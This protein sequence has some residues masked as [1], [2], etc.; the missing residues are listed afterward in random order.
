MSAHNRSVVANDFH[1]QFRDKKV[2]SLFYN[3]LRREKPDKIILAG[4]VTDFYSISRFDKNPARKES[5]Q[6]ELDDSHKMLATIRRAAPNAKIIFL[7]GN[8]EA[9]LTK[10]LWSTAKALATLRSLEIESLLQ[11]K[12]LN[13]QYETDGIWLGDL[14]VYHGTIVRAKAAYTAHA[15]LLKNGCSGMS[16]HTHRDGKAAVRHRGGQLCWWENFCMCQLDAEYIKGIA[17]W[18]QGWSLVTVTG[19]RPDVEQ[20]AVMGGKY[21]YRGRVFTR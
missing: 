14:F 4:D 1:G 3:F 10:Y 6:E 19:K 13:I 18:T 20:I 15:E 17:N 12:K 5:L 9:R 11:L 7:Q 21:N 2:C 16:G 8:H